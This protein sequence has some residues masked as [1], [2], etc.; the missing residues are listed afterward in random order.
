M[1]NLNNSISNKKGA[2][3]QKAC[4]WEAKMMAKQATTKALQTA[5][6]HLVPVSEKNHSR[7][8]AAKN[9]RKE[10]K[11]VFPNTKFSVVGDSF[12]GGD[13][14]RICWK[15]GA[16]TEQVEAI[17]NKYKAGHFDCLQD[18]YEYNDTA[19]TDAFGDAKYISTSRDYSLEFITATIRGLAIEH[20]DGD[21]PTAEQ[22]KSGSLYYKTPSRHCDSWQDLI[23]RA[24]VKKVF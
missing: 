19:W 10:L 16:T 18:L 14:I 12:A 1:D 22:F 17:T 20:H 4:E 23:Y 2:P 24:M 21:L 7:V 15:D 6:P 13:A 3:H 5:N 9:I 11:K 8:A